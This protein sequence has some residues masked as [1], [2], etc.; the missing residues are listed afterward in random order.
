[1]PETNCEVGDKVRVTDELNGHEFEIGEIVT[2]ERI[3]IYDDSYCCSNGNESWFLTKDEFEPIK[4]S[5]E[6]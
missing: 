3:Y 5:E 4:E 1:M 2:I 6:K